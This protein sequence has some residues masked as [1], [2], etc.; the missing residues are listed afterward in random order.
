MQDWKKILKSIY[1]TDMGSLWPLANEVWNNG[2]ASNK[3]GE[4]LHPTLVERVTACKTITHSFQV[5]LK[6]TNRVTTQA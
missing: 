5:L 4:N 6:I 2:F 3:T 1:T